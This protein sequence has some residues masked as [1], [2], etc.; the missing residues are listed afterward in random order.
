MESSDP[1]SNIDDKIGDLP[2]DQQVFAKKLV[3]KFSQ[4]KEIISEEEGW[5]KGTE[6]DGFLVQTKKTDEGL[7]CVRGQGKMNF[8]ADKVFEFLDTDG[9]IKKYDSSYKE[10][11]TIETPDLGIGLNFSYSRY[12][13]GTM[14]SDRDFCFIG[15]HI[16]EENGTHIICYTSAEH[17]E[18]PAVKKAVRGELF[19]GGW[20]IQQDSEDPENSSYAYYISQTNPKGSIP[21]YF[22]NKF[23]EGQGFLP[24]QIN[25]I[26]TK[27]SS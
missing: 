20:V 22:V 3:S 24:K 4:M 13:G 5:K 7:N 2:E 23:S 14:I 6:K 19:I 25:E 1:L 9:S 12:K 26:L 27:E 18:A 8:S 21:K 10:G 15:G 11:K 17:P 16:K